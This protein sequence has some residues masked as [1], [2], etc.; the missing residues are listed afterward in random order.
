[1]PIKVARMESLLEDVKEKLWELDTSTRNNL[2]FYGV[3]EEVEGGHQGEEAQ[4][5][6]LIRTTINISREVP[7]LR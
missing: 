5:R 6:E 3:K 1:M 4:V 2:V 7:F